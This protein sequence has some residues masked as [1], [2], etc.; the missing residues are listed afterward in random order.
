MPFKEEWK[1]ISDYPD[2]EVS[3]LGAARNRKTKLIKMQRV[4]KGT[5]YVTVNLYPRNKAN[6]KVLL[7]HRLVAL[8]FIPNTNNL[9]CVNHIDE[10]KQNNYVNNLE[11]VTYKTNNQRGTR[12]KRISNSNKGKHYNPR[13][14]FP[15]SVIAISPSGKRYCFN[16]ITECA[17]AL[18]LHRSSISYVLHGKMKRTKGFV[19]KY[20]QGSLS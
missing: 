8:A 13:T 16:S 9:P 2:Y 3:N 18:G 5:G 11:W 14:H 6:H 17:N 4:T 12:G 20:K 19:I 10:N 15:K 7:V 1:V